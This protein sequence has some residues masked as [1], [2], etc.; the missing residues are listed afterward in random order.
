MT[1]NTKKFY[2]SIDEKQSKKDNTS[3]TIRMNRL[4]GSSFL[5]RNYKS[6]GKSIKNGVQSSSQNKKGS[7]I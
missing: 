5:S 7:Y 4:K 2:S 3:D 1:P 6:L